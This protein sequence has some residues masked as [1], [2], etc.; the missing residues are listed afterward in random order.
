MGDKRKTQRG[1]A[2]LEQAIVK[3]Y[4]TFFKD[5]SELFRKNPQEYWRQCSRYLEREKRKYL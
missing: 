4:K 1:V 3:M 5:N 2:D